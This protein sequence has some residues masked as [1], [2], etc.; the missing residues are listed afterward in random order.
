MV[1]V[2]G[3]GIAGDGGVLF[4]ERGAVDYGLEFV[5]EVWARFDDFECGFG[6]PVLADF[7]HPRCLIGVAFDEVV[8]A[9]LGK[10]M[11]YASDVTLTKLLVVEPYRGI[12]S[13]VSDVVPIW[14]VAHFLGIDLN[15]LAG[16]I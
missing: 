6:C 9:R 12:G 11:V 10:I 16:L 3:E 13:D 5:D 1:V 15:I 2:V 7:G 4:D 8:D 14:A